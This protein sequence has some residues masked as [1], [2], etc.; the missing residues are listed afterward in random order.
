MGNADRLEV[1]DQQLIK[2]YLAGDAE[3]F[4]IL[5]ERYKRQLYAY[6][7]NMLDNRQATADDLFQQ[8]WLKVVDKLPRYHNRD[9]FL[10]W[11]LRIAHNAAIDHFRRGKKHKNELELDAE[12][13]PEIAGAAGDE[14][15]RNMARSELENA[16]ETALASIQP[17][18][19]E[20]F[21]FRQDGLS[22]KE[23]ALVQKCSI[24]TALARMQYALK[25]L[26][27]ILAGWKTGGS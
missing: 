20:V 12:D 26:Q 14:P 1:P 23:I 6:L 25:N 18:Q 10:G 5:Y 4:E 7:N 19:R 3:S 13:T 16:L 11:V 2:N 17:E 8:V 9:R 15:W 24:N 22:F 27:V 21:L